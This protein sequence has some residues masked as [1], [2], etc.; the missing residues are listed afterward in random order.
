M[1]SYA[2]VT[3]E[4]S[5]SKT[6]VACMWPG[7]LTGCRFHCGTEIFRG[8]LLSCPSEGS[9]TV[10]SPCSHLELVT[11]F[12]PLTPSTAAPPMWEMVTHPT[13]TVNH[14]N[15]HLFTLTVK[16][17]QLLPSP[18]HVTKDS[19][20]KVHAPSRSTSDICSEQ[21]IYFWSNF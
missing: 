7:G 12:S 11:S 18:L 17:S 20:Y 5:S 16:L 6:G 15:L 1:I 10:P 9:L 2:K 13:L 4:L 14:S 8:R 3:Y 19:W 21:F